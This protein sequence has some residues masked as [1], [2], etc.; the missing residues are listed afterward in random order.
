MRSGPAEVD[1]DVRAD[2]AVW[3]TI[4]RPHKHNALARPVLDALAAA[5]RAAGDDSR[6][7]CVLLRGAGDQYFAAG[8]D[9]VDLAS[10]RTDAEIDQMNEM[11]TAAL[12]AVRNCP[13]PVIAYLNGD[14]LGGGAEL[15]VA[16]DLRLMAPHARI[17]FIHGRLGIT[18]AWGGG[19]DLC[20]LIGPSRA[21]RMMS[22]CELVGAA[23]ALD[24]GLADLEAHDGPD[25]DDVAAFLEP[26]LARTPLVLRGIKAQVL[27]WRHGLP[28]SE[29]RATERKHLRATWASPEH[30]EVVARFLA[31]DRT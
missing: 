6:S 22:R 13:I 3:I 8:G 7:R 11:A 10:V 1:V 18:S 14:A 5:V 15:A 17:G 29:R 16:S 28:L 9:L 30:W 31:K 20:A 26:I 12:D 21:M 24:W 27:A 25:G 19:P 23:Q 4:D 2:G